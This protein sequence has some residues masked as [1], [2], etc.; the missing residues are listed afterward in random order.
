MANWIEKNIKWVFTMPAVI[1][2]GL[3]MVVPV[4]YTFW[5]SFHE[6]SMS[7]IHPPLWVAFQNYAELFQDEL[8]V[9]SLGLCFILPLSL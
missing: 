3:M 6:W 5:L 4:G 7:N 1:F 8:F 9:K 2:V